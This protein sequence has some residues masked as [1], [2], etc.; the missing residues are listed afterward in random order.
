MSQNTP[1]QSAKRTGP[2]T[3]ERRFVGDK[4][5]RTV[6]IHLIRAH[7]KAAGPLK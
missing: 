3:I 7:M 5:A 2:Y 6:A 4:T 1:A